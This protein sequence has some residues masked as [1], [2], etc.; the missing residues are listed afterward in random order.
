MR[1]ILRFH[2]QK[3]DDERVRQ[4]EASIG[5]DDELYLHLD[6]KLHV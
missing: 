5:R 4:Q 2:G 3:M 1:E 6:R